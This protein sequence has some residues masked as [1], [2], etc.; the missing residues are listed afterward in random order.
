[1]GWGEEGGVKYWSVANSWG[2]GWGEQGLFRVLRGDN[3]C[4]VRWGISGALQGLFR[5]LR[6]TSTVRYRKEKRKNQRWNPACYCQRFYFNQLHFEF[7]LE[8]NEIKDDL[9]CRLKSLCLEVGLN[10]IKDDLYCR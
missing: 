10:E 8:F 7:V 5:V 2:R 9:Y 6:G 1:M 3:H 4:K